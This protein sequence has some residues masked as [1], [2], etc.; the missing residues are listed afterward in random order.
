LP[1]EIEQRKKKKKIEEEE[2]EEEEEEGEEGGGGGGKE[3]EEGTLKARERKGLSQD[4][5]TTKSTDG[6]EPT[7]PWAVGVCHGPQILQDHMWSCKEK[8]R[9]LSEAFGKVLSC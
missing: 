1:K 9:S 8:P 2:K 4:P 3:E 7:A 5:R 6:I